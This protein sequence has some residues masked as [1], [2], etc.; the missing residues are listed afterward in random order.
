MTP[1]PLPPA[2]SPRRWTVRLPA[3]VLL[4]SALL[5]ACGGSSEATSP[6][7]VPAAAATPAQ[8]AALGA[9]P[10]APADGRKRALFALSPELLDQA[11]WLLPY[12]EQMYSAAFPPSANAS[13]QRS[14]TIR[15]R[16]YASTNNCV[17]FD[18][19]HLYALGPVVGSL[20]TPIRVI[21]IDDF[22]T[23][24]P[25][26]CGLRLNKSMQIQGLDR[27]YVVYLPYK[28]LGSA[29]TPAVFML[30][31]T[32]GSGPEFY[33]RSGWR[34][35]ADA[36]GFVAVFP[37]ALRHCYTD[38][39]V[40]ETFTKWSGGSLGGPRL[41]LCTES[42]RATL[43]PEAAAATDHP[44]ADDL[45]FL[46]AVVA[47]IVAQHGVDPHRV[48]VSG[49]SN[50]GQMS[51]RLARDASDLFAAAAVNAGTMDESLATPAP[52]AMSMVVLIGELDDRFASFAPD[53]ALPMTES[54]VNESYFQY[55]TGNLR[56]VLSL[57]DTP[58]TWQTV[59]VFGD[60]VSLFQ[61]ASS[62]LVP[63]AG[64]QLFVGIVQGLPHQYPGYMPDLLWPWFQ[65]QR[66]P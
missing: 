31:G 40:R 25:G 53:G 42:E 58:Y 57:A 12:I 63:A 15:Y 41:P 29:V 28:A 56:A 27:N 5:G 24:H 1:T 16:C 18:G 51:A 17:G 7:S 44:L 6:F 26:A 3:L 2:P 9:G 39:G 35:K 19:T 36:E 20:G 11:D 37:S 21:S 4:A 38:A 22:C 52:R 10:V 61:Y 43:P 30:H 66:L 54:I 34:E 23:T 55:M 60:T 48:Y 59:Q 13:T 64:N 46:R 14:G 33:E 8:A 62:T 32:S 45:G 50:G 47:D 49:F 65:T